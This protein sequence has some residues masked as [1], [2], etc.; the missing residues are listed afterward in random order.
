MRS[1]LANLTPGLTI[2]WCYLIW[3]LVALVLYFDPSPQLWGTAAGVSLLVGFGLLFST[4]SF[5]HAPIALSRWQVF[6]FF[7]MPFAVSSFS[8]LAKGQGFVLI[9]FPD[10]RQTLLACA[11]CATFCLARLGAR[12]GAGTAR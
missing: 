2:L 9:L 7:M 3:Y 11:C 5:P 6:R 4:T 8:G 12:R 10:S 1:Y